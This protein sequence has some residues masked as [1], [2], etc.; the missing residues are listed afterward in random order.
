MLNRFVNLLPARPWPAKALAC[1]TLFRL[2]F[3]SLLPACLFASLPSFSLSF[4]PLL[5]PPASFLLP[6]PLSSSLNLSS[7]KAFLELCQISPRAFPELFQSSAR[8]LLG[9]PQSSLK[10]QSSPRA[11][12]D[13]SQ[14]SPRALPELFQISPRALP[15]LIHSCSSAPGNLRSQIPYLSQN[16]FRISSSSTEF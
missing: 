9:F 1:Q 15:V 11:L 7:P 4:S 2:C 8:S 16:S 12:P 5:Y 6:C 10:A 3:S 14:S 13:L